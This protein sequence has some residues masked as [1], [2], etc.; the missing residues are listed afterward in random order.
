[1]LTSSGLSLKSL[2]FRKESADF[3]IGHRK[4]HQWYAPSRL[5]AALLVRFSFGTLSTVCPSAPALPKLPDSW[6]TLAVAAQAGAQRLP[7]DLM[8]VYRRRDRWR[9]WREAAWPQA[10]QR[11]CALPETDHLADQLAA[12][13]WLR[14]QTFVE[15]KRIAL[16]GNSFGGIE[17]VLGAE[18]ESYCAAIDASGGAQN[19]AQA[20][21]LRVQMTR[22]VQNSRA[23]FSFS[24]RERRP[25][26][27]PHSFRGPERIGKNVRNEDLPSLRQITAIGA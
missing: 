8:Q 26:A 15:P 4:R 12:L 6:P 17:A 3:L 27:E 16:V 13:A 10:Q 24:S 18:R 25:L 7:L 21:E 19:W 23:P 20:P 5:L 14:K 2:R 22:A 11:W 9:P 1:V